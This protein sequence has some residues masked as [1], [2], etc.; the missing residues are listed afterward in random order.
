M[1]CHT[2]RIGGRPAWARLVRRCGPAGR[3][4]AVAA[5]TPGLR[6]VL[7]SVAVVLVGLIGLGTLGC[8]PGIRWQGYVFDPVYA[9]SR[10]ENKLTFVYFRNWYAV[11]CTEFEESVLKQPVVRE[12]V[13]NL[14]SV[15]LSFDWD[16]PLADRWGIRQTPAFVIVDPEGRVLARGE[17]DI[18]LEALLDAIEQAKEE[19]TPMTQPAV[20]P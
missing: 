8:S 10:A 2:F 17:G 13:A 7:A 3:V 4:K 20:P 18:S 6:R 1:H 9:K 16:R 12:A 15:A 19:F 5:D 11:E 14:I